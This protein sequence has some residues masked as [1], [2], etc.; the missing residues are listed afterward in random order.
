MHLKLVTRERE[1]QRD[2][3]KDSFMG[4]VGWPTMNRQ[5]GQRTNLLWFNIH[6]YITSFEDIYLEAI[7]GR[8]E[9]V[10]FKISRYA[11]EPT[12]PCPL[13]GQFDH[14]YIPFGVMLHWLLWLMTFWMIYS[15]SLKCS[16]R[17][18]VSCGWRM[19]V[20]LMRVSKI[21]LQFSKILHLSQWIHS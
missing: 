14:A 7:F 9:R 5:N 3:K 16:G 13:N 21:C 18:V 20:C 6:T 11:F 12:P 4:T 1:R 2:S 15:S 8:R 17:C 10:L 19:I